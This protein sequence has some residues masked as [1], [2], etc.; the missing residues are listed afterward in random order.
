[1]PGGARGSARMPSGRAPALLIGLA[2]R[3]WMARK[4]HGA[5]L[6]SHT[7]VA[8]AIEI[9]VGL[10]APCGAREWAVPEQLAQHTRVHTG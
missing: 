7:T 2:I 1:M 4:T 8:Q 6:C 9:G 5:A 10:G 3:I